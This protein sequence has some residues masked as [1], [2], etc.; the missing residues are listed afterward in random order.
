MRLP[1]HCRVVDPSPPLE[2]VTTIAQVAPECVLCFNVKQG[3]W[4]VWQ[5]LLRAPEHMTLAVDWADSEGKYADLDPG[6]VEALRLARMFSPVDAHK[7]TMRHVEQRRKA[8]QAI[9]DRVGDAA[10]Q[11]LSYRQRVALQ[12]NQPTGLSREDLMPGLRDLSDGD[13]AEAA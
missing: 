4:Q 13:A 10:E 5:P 7:W 12:D 11:G 1:A 6:I 9:L 8:E 3:R 2:F